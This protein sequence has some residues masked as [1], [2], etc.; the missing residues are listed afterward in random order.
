MAIMQVNPLDQ[1]R[2]K[3]S[4]WSEVVGEESLLP[5]HLLPWLKVLVVLVVLAVLVTPCLYHNKVKH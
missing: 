3:G 2:T 5:F 1:L 4:Y